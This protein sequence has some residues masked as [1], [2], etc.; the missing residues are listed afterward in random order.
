VTIT[1]TSGT[2]YYMLDGQDPRLR[3]G[4][5]HPSAR[6]YGGPV[7]IQEN[8]RIVTRSRQTN[9]TWSAVAAATYVVDAVRLVFSE[10]MYHPTLSETSGLY[11]DEDFE[12]V[13][14]MNADTRHIDMSGVRFADG[15]LFTFPEG[16]LLPPGEYIVVVKNLAAFR[17][18]YGDDGIAIAGTYSGSLDNIGERV[19]LEGPLR[20]PVFEVR[21]DDDWELSTDGR[22]H[23]LVLVDPYDPSGNWGV[24]ASWKASVELFGSPGRE[25]GTG[26]GGGWQLP[27]DV[28]QDGELD[29]SDA[30]GLLRH[31]FGGVSLALP[32]DGPT[33][34]EGG[35]LTLLDVNGDSGVDLGDA[36]YT[37]AYL[38]AGGLAPELG[39]ACV[40]I[41]GCPTAC[42]W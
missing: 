42:A 11:N 1:A 24:K 21:Y 22:G 36:V 16:T 38:F 35:T 40:R 19:A 4:S 2:I 26:P 15:I 25:D 30:V 33:I 7:T 34:G 20:E 13:E 37:L 8:T 31:L 12:F 28:N 3:G 39:T 14:I 5:I 18:R 9:G 10:I 6:V 41:E 23:S 27:G 17:S 32:C 29:I